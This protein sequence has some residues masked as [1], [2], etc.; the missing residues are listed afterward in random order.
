MWC[1]RRRMKWVSLWSPSKLQLCHA[2]GGCKIVRGGQV[3]ENLESCSAPGLGLAEH[4][5]GLPKVPKVFSWH[6][7]V[8]VWW[9]ISS[10]RSSL[11]YDAPA[12]NVQPLFA[13]SLCSMPRV[14][15]HVTCQSIGVLLDLDIP[16]ASTE[17]QWAFPNQWLP[18]IPS[19]DII[20]VTCRL[21]V[22][23]RLA[24]TNLEILQRLNIKDQILIF[25][26]IY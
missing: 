24:A 13:W 21:F 7:G 18:S 15:T 22:G 5:W 20:S 8:I 2:D 19:P 14:T 23:N 26:T 3:H 9:F 6:A 1:R 11:H 12:V 25:L 17:K 4:D 10:D 16:I